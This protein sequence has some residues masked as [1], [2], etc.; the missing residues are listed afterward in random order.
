MCCF[1]SNF[2]IDVCQHGE[3]RLTSASAGEKHKYVA[4]HVDVCL[5]GVW[6]RVCGNSWT[7]REAV[8]VCRQ[9]FG[10]DN[11][12]GMFYIAGI[13]RCDVV[14]VVTIVIVDIFVGIEVI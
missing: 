8:V 2:V 5:D 4:G 1:L 11:V 3:V 10:R 14:V 9:L 7:S 6:S 12:M 13:R